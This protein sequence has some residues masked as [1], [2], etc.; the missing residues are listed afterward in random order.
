M[1]EKARSQEDKRHLLP[2]LLDLSGRSVVIF[3]GG[4][5]GER[6]ARLFC[7]HAR[8]VVVSKSFSA[9]LLQMAE[10]GLAELI[11][12]DLSADFQEY[13]KDAFI[14]IPATSDRVLNAALEEAAV[15]RGVLVNKVDEAG[16]VVVP[17]ILRRD[18]L[19]I[20]IS[21][22]SPALS[23]YLRLKLQEELTGNYQEMA[24]LLAQMRKELKETVPGQARRS[25][26]IWSILQDPEVWRLLDLSYEKAYMR[27]REHVIPG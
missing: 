18:P 24:R 16:Q 25:K 8:V 9:G 6:K 11:C 4:R 7:G 2:L 20:A 22:E 21:T 13:L 27:A 12:A 26:I 17:S 5:V 19:T 14:A 15:S 3:G 10:K 23:K 1:A